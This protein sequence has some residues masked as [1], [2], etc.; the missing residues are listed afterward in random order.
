M[1]F[2]RHIL[3]LASVCCLL[4]PYAEAQNTI[5]AEATSLTDGERWT[6]TASLA[7]TATY[8][9][10]QADVVLPDGVTLEDGSLQATA[11]LQDHN[12]SATTLSDGRV[13]IVAYSNTNTAIAEST[14]TLFSINLVAETPLTE[15]ATVTLRNLLFTDDEYNEATL[16][17]VTVALSPKQTTLRGDVNGDGTVN[18]LDI[19][20][21]ISIVLGS[22]SDT[23]DTAAADL[24]NDDTINGLDI[25]GLIN[26]VLTA[27]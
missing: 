2:L 25:V 27:Q 17:A 22:E 7:N 19:V 1:H 12:V 15:A 8:I 16:P 13:R 21:V 20:A 4:S 23:Y 26:L 9:A 24:N 10:F 18:G 11:R 5:T 14:G 3:I 6:L